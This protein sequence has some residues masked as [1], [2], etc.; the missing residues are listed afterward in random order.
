MGRRS[1]ARQHRGPELQGRAAS[2]RRR[3][4]SPVALSRRSLVPADGLLATDFFHIGT[5]ALTRLYV[6]FVMEIHTR[7]V[8]LLGVTAH[9]TAAW[10]TQ[11]ARN[12]LND[13]GDRANDFA[14]LVRDRDPAPPNRRRHHQRVSPSQLTN[15]NNTAGQTP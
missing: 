13:L 3:R 14:Y 12:L 5:I 4:Y 7:R 9:P 1:T 15:H 2:S 6:F 8:H 11:Q 10:V